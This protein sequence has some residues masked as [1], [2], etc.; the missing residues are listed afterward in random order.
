MS[1]QLKLTN[2]NTHVVDILGSVKGRDQPVMK[3]DKAVE[4]VK[5]LDE[6][7]FINDDYV[8]FDPFLKLEKFY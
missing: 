4:L 3:M 8:F 5:C 7:F 1:A 6:E 2:V